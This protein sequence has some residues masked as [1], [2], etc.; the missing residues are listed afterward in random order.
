MLQG[1]LHEHV[2]VYISY[3]VK[4]VV[5]TE[6]E[7]GSDLMKFTSQIANPLIEHVFKLNRSTTVHDALVLF[8]YHENGSK[9]LNA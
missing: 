2:T 4:I 9:K 1:I 6:S 7:S 5:W 3:N 8:R